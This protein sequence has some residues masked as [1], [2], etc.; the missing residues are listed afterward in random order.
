M[1]SKR[2]DDVVDQIETK[3]GRSR[4]SLLKTGAV[5]IPTIVTLHASPAW[6]TTDYTMVAYQYGANRGLCRNPNFD[7]S[8][9]APWKREEFMP[10][11][12][13]RRKSFAGDDE[14]EGAARS[15]T[16]GTKAPRSSSDVI[17]F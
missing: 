6:A 4:R 12:E 16:S 8:S 17:E 3:A 2:S 9:S 15:A 10:C 11:G 1:D 7:P 14:V 13:I 5:V